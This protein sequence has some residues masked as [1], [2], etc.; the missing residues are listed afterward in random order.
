VSAFIIAGFLSCFGLAHGDPIAVLFVG[1]AFA[2][3]GAAVGAVVAGMR[4]LLD[5]LENVQS[6]IRGLRWQCE[7]EYQSLVRELKATITEIRSLR[8]PDQETDPQRPTAI[9]EL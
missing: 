7:H 1:T 2:L 3:A 6:E 9:K 8:W 5:E 4:L